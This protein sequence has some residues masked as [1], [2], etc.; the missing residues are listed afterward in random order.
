MEFAFNGGR[1]ISNDNDLNYREVLDDF[2]NAKII[3]IITYN[4][5]KNQRSDML[6]EALKDTNADIQFITNVPSRMDEYYNTPAGKNMRYVARKNI[7]IYVSKLNPANFGNQFIPL[8]NVKNHAKLIGTENI[9][10]IG[11]A[12]YSNESANNVEA[13]VLIE[14]KKFIQK[15]YTKFFDNIKKGSLSYYEE[16][17]SA[18]RLFVLALKA[19]FE[20]HYH[21]M[22]ENLYTNY[23]GSKYTVADSVFMDVSDLDA[24]YRDLDELDSVCIAADNTYD[25]SNEEYNDALERLKGIFDRISV[26]WLKDIISEGGTLYQLVTF[27]VEKETNDILQN[28]YSFEAYDE[29]LD[30]CVEKAMN[31]ASEMYSARRDAFEYDAEDFLVEIQNILYALDMAIQFTTKWKVSKIN[32]EI[33]NT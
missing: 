9:I 28:E 18:F 4:I 25:E 17:F 26:D 16:N 12:N 33:D 2:K 31:S 3:R 6:L 19:K 20:C 24:L 29:Y 15:V 13:G 23:K 32:P 5:S 21:K 30:N 1:F 27:D 22:M 11:S 8:F 10:Y 14:D 7:Q